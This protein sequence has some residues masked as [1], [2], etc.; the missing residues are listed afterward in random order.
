[1]KRRWTPALDLVLI[2]TAA[3][4]DQAA[5]EEQERPAALPA[6]DCAQPQ[7]ACAPGAEVP[8]ERARVN[9]GDAPTLG[10]ATAPVTLVV[11]SDFECPFC[12]RGADRLDA[13]EAKY[14]EN[15]RI[16]FK[17]RPLPF[18]RSARLAAKAALA[19]G[20]Q[21]KFWAYH[22]QLFENQKA[23]DRASLIAHASSLDLDVERFESDLDSRA[24]EERIQADEMEAERLG[25]KGTPTFFVNGRRVTGAQPMEVFA[26]LI[27]GELKR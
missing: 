20:E 4:C 24:L 15:V 17:Q 26:R 2:L 1:M 6:P 21:G 9:V 14:G 13:L 27:D 7:A 18:H 23:L 25:V 10:P 11:F 5:A 16:A 8:T 22:D 19:A 12:R 3:A